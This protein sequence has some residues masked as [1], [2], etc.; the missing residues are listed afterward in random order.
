MIIEE[1][2]D[3]VSL[4][5]YIFNLK[6]QYIYIHAFKFILLILLILP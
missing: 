6:D 1:E 3:L 4:F 5:N 2:R